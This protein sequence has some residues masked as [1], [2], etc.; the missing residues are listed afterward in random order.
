M[1]EPVQ[2]RC[3]S[4]LEMAAA[5]Y[6]RLSPSFHG[7]EGL[8]RN[9]SSMMP[10]YPVPFMGV[11]E[12]STIHESGF[13]VSDIKRYEPLDLDRMNANQWISG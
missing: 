11:R 13:H 8:P 10:D 3:Q 4:I 12:N 9:G 7:R 6:I 2:V 5:P 1:K